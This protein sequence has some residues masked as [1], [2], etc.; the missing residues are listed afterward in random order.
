M[1]IE[2]QLTDE[3]VLSELGSRLA[4]AR[5]QQNLSQRALGESAGVDRLT[6]QQLEAGGAVKVI[7]LIRVLRALGLLDTLEQLVPE[8]GPSPIEQLE[9]RGR[10][11]RRA[12][13]SRT[14]GRPEPPRA[15]PWRW[16]D[17][18]A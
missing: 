9:L 12:S 8:P 13:G 6:I 17:Q 16:G 7:S 2:S 11:R 1:R 3:A 4:H 14:A 10:R 15:R 5:L 18:S